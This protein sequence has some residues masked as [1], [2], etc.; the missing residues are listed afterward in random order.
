MEKYG[1]ISIDFK[2]FG[3]EVENLRIPLHQSSKLII[4]ELVDIYNY[5]L[6]QEKKQL[7]SFKARLSKKYISKNKTLLEENIKDGELLEIV[8]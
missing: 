8:K 7:Y 3:G 1:N 6:I 2:N 4:D 5:E